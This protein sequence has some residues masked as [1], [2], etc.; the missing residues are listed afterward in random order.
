[1]NHTRLL[2]VALALVAAASIATWLVSGSQHSQAG[3]ATQRLGRAGDSLEAMLTEQLAL[4]TFADT[5]DPLTAGSAIAAA[6][7]SFQVAITA[8]QALSETPAERRVVAEEAAAEQHWQG[9]S[10]AT[11]TGHL[12][13]ST[14]IDLK[15]ERALVASVRSDEARLSDL[16]IRAAGRNQDKATAESLWLLA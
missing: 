4:E 16:Q 8:L 6:H 3:A 7:R 2:G 14:A 12:P 11:V 10:F 13:R 1:M 9:L 5:R 15:P